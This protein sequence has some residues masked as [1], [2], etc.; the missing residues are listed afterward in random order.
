MVSA[1]PGNIGHRQLIFN[2]VAAGMSDPDFHQELVIG[3]AVRFF[4]KA[5]KRLPGKVGKGSE[6]F[7]VNDSFIIAE[8]KLINR[9]QS[10]IVMGRAV[11]KKTFAGQLLIFC[12]VGNFFQDG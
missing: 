10:A 1:A 4:K 9:L 7:Q 3:F 2:K 8:G 5:A 12:T 11:I 6:F